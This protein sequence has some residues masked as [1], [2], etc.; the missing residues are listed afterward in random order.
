MDEDGPKREFKGLRRWEN[1]S[2]QAR[3]GIF[4]SSVTRKAPF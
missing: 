2:V 3:M 4:E 1:R